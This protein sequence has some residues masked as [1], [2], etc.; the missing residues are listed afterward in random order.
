MAKII[1]WDEAPMSHKHQMEALDRTLR[2]ITGSDMPF[3]GKVIVLSGDFRQC[4]PV[5][6][7][8]NRAEIVNSAL[9]RSH[10]WGGFKVLQLRENMR[11]RMSEDP[12]IEWFDAFTLK[13]GDGSVETDE[14]TDMIEIPE[15][16][17]LKME[18]KD[19]FRSRC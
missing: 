9:N 17:Y 6:P 1:V 16:M 13:I 11:V 2:D 18:P 12:D 3:G 14:N 7:H 10:L 15:E 5:I 19:S 8:A 4:L